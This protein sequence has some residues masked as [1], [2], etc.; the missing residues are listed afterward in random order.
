[1]EANQA[2]P[3]PTTREESA[4]LNPIQTDS[5]TQAKDVTIT[6]T[7]TALAKA[8]DPTTTQT[9][10]AG[11][12]ISSGETS[13]TTASKIGIGLGVGVGGL[14]LMGIVAV[15]FY[16][17][18]MAHGRNRE[19]VAELGA[20][21]KAIP[22]LTSKDMGYI[23]G[24]CG[25]SHKTLAASLSCNAETFELF[26]HPLGLGLNLVLPIDEQPPLSMRPAEWGGNSAPPKSSSTSSSSGSSE[27]S[28]SAGSSSTESSSGSSTISARNSGQDVR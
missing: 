18:G 3:S 12:A 13:L 10:A 23:G 17:K 20:E 16:R 15:L 25:D 11:Q 27:T 6:E 22:Q 5:A 9:A 21:E 24:T 28:S 26:D 2:P 7:T 8:T 19:C 4:A 1:M 14:L